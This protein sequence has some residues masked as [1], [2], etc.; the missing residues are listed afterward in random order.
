MRGLGKIY[1]GACAAVLA[2][3]MAVPAIA[4]DGDAVITIKGGKFEPSEVP[5]A[6]GK[7]L[8]I[9]VRNQDA[10]AAEFESSDFHREKMVQPGG[11]ITVFV[12]PLD[13]GSYEFFDDLHPEDRGHLVVK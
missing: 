1:F 5:V 2:L 8:K 7:K 9:I 4:D 10:T 12:G 11:E 6:A 3:G 13:A